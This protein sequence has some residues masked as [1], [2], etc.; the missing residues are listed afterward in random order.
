MNFY[1]A[2]DTFLYWYQEIQASAIF[3]PSSWTYWRANRNNRCPLLSMVNFYII[4][5]SK[6]SV[7]FVETKRGVNLTNFDLYGTINV[8]YKSPEPNLRHVPSVV[9]RF[10]QCLTLYGKGIDL[11]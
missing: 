10:A 3:I 1:N 2:T 5:D 4:E 6:F 11:S 8:C 7:K 9:T